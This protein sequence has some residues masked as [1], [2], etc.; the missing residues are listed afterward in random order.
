MIDFAEKVMAYTD[1]LDQAGF[2]ASGMTYDAT[3]RNL[4]S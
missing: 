2:E 3:L 1:G 4:W